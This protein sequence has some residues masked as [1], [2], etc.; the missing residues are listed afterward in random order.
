VSSWL[1]VRPLI[2][3]AAIVAGALAILQLLLAQGVTFA[4]VPPPETTAEQLVRAVQAHRFY[5]AMQLLSEPLQAQ[6]AED[7]F[8]GIAAEIREAHGGIAQAHGVDAQPAGDTATATAR[9]RLEDRSETTLEFPLVKE[10]GEWR[11]A[12]ID[13]LRRLATQ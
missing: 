1:A 2:G 6:V 10:Q 9:V 5:G 8:R 3:A 7:D 4:I 12:S 13:P 11:V